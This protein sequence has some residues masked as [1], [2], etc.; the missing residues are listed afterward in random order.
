MIFNVYILYSPTLKKHYTGFSKF[1][2]KRQ[3]QHN[4]TQ[5]SWTS[6][7]SDWEKVWTIQVSSIKKARDLEKKI[8]GQGAKRF[9]TR[10]KKQSA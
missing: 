3:R 4:K 6:K 2:I 10:Q 9:L 1:T 8:K 7:A 5:T